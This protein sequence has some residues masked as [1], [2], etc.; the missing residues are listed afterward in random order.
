MRSTRRWPPSARGWRPRLVRLCR[1]VSGSADAAEDVA[2][3]TLLEAIRLL[4][5]LRDPD[6][7]S[8]WVAAIARHV[9]RRWSRARGRELAHITSRNPDDA[10]DAEAFTGETLE[11]LAVGVMLDPNDP[12]A[13]VE[14]ESSVSRP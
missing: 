3:E 11:S 8:A 13:Q 7:V 5:R 4:D 12:A 14:R 2:Q 1:Q 10:G 9:C 6:G